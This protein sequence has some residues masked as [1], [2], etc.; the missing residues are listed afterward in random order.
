[1]TFKKKILPQEPYKYFKT[2]GN[3]YPSDEFYRTFFKH[4][5]KEQGHQETVIQYTGKNPGDAIDDVMRKGAVSLGGGCKAIKCPQTKNPAICALMPCPTQASDE[6]ICSGPTIETKKGGFIREEK[7]VYTT[8]RR[9]RERCPYSILR[10]DRYSEDSS[11]YTKLQKLN[12]DLFTKLK[13][14]SSDYKVDKS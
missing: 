8:K 6:L 4:L 13:T 14:R 9:R 2:K 7:T 3:R 12:M 11:S 1:M 10:F 5:L